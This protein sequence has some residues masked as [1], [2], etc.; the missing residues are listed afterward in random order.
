MSNVAERWWIVSIRT[1]RKR[2][3]Q[4]SVRADTE[5]DAR[6]LACPARTDTITK[7]DLCS[8]F[9][10]KVTSLLSGSIAPSDIYEALGDCASLLKVGVP[11]QDAI[12]LQLPK[13]TSPVLRY[14]LFMVAKALVDQGVGVPDAF[15]GRPRICDGNLESIIRIGFESGK[16]VQSFQ[17]MR[18]KTR[19]EKRFASKMRG[20]LL[21]P[22]ITVAFLFILCIFFGFVIIPKVE[23]IYT[24]FKA[25]LPTISQPTFFLARLMR[26]YALISLPT[27]FF[28]AGWL[29]AK[30]QKIMR[31]QWVRNILFRLPVIGPFMS[32][33]DLIDAVRDLSI[34]LKTGIPL[35][36]AMG[37]TAPKL[38]NPQT[39]KA[40]DAIN[41]EITVRG[42]DASIAFEKYAED[43]GEEGPVVAAIVR[44]GEQGT[45]LP[46]LLKE[47][48]DDY[49]FQVD[50]KSE[51]VLKVVGPVVN[52][53]IF[54]CAGF[55][56]LTTYLPILKLNDLITGKPDTTQGPVR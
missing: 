1:A 9:N 38:S 29:F 11:F 2:N 56:L 49:T 34:L 10:A 3:K 23:G 53:I 15:K 41:Q 7:V 55:L 26:E 17:D 14:E 32:M 16:M 42:V 36:D 37:L 31:Q 51:D 25:P 47:K 50:E 28:G 43:L 30:R 22:A 52:I 35:N 19:K 48:A 21:Q 24:Q 20:A 54:I 27:L 6:I 4:V 13:I 39:R 33:V 40:W 45:N 8:E 12:H 44:I 46:V 18:E 5:A